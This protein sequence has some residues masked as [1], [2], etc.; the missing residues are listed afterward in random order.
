MA[1]ELSK[2]FHCPYDVSCIV[3][4]SQVFPADTY[5]AECCNISYG[6]EPKGNTVGKCTAHISHAVVTKWRQFIVKAVEGDWDFAP[7]SPLRR[8]GA[9]Q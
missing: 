2:D 3:C 6:Y 9:E 5:M 1:I 4:R 7:D 8:K